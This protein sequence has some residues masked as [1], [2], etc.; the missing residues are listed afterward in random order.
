MLK[1]EINNYA[2]ILA[3]GGGTRLWPKS[4]SACPKQFMKL[5][6]EKTLLQ[7]TFKRIKT[8]ISLKNIYVVCAKEYFDEVRKQ[9]PDLLAP[10][11][12]VEYEPKNTAASIA[13]A[14]LTIHKINSH[15]VVG[16]FASDHLVKNE[17]QFTQILG[18]AY[19]QAEKSFDIVTIGIPPTK[20][21][22]GMG[23]VHIGKQIEEI[24][25]Q[26]I[27]QVQRFLEKPDLALA[28]AFVASGEYF[29]NASYFVAKTE[30]FLNAYNKCL[31]E[32]IETL[33]SMDGAA[34]NEAKKIWQ[35]L[36]NIAIDYGIM[37]KIQNISMV[38]GDFGWSDIGNWAVISEVYKGNQNGNVF[39][40][41]SEDNNVLVETKNCLVYG[42]EKLI[43]L[44]GVE[45]LIVVEDKDVILITSKDKV[46]KVKQVVERLKSEG[47][48]NY[49]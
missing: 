42:Q 48:N 15:A 8:F 14:V 38:T 20:A 40:G 10:Q 25:K 30:T 24:R 33:S 6:S 19:E 23:Y 3:G 46:Q 29:W 47:K 7:D 5:A 34:S 21:D 27:F 4:R 32:I 44:V 2:V 37:E 1:T 36:K 28:K 43:A 18:V 49:L 12:L 45:N 22:D 17:K 39:L 41:N 16:S 26:P 31:P 35:K 13:L 9:L 11:I